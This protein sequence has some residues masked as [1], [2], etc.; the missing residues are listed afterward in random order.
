[1][2]KRLIILLMLVLTLSLLLIP[3]LG[4]CTQKVRVFKIYNC[5]DYIEDENGRKNKSSI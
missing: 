4:G 5:Q 1:M 3:A 2:K